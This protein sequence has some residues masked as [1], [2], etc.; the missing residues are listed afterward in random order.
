MS[1]DLWFLF[2]LL[3]KMA[4][5][6]GFVVVASIITERAGPAIG[7][8][9]STLPVS[10]GPSF[11]F[12]SLDHD[13]AFIEG[14]ALGSL[15]INAVTAFFALSYVL[16]AQRRSLAVSLAISLL[17]WF[18]LTVAIRQFDWTTA[19]I[20]VLNI[21]AFAIC[22]PLGQRFRHAKMPL[23]TR[24][25]YDVPLRAAMVS[26]LVAIVVT[27]SRWVGPTM[28]GTIA[29]YPIVFTCLILILHPRIGGPA[30]AA[31]L[32]HGLWGLIGFG[33]ATLVLQHAAVPL[34]SPA[35]LS[36]ALATAIAWNFGLWLWRRAATRRA[37]RP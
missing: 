17:V 36:L 29:T 33:A 14:A 10:A 22:I 28:S 32:A 34:G 8:L 35:A 20:I 23:M 9:V 31:V 24:R 6:A 2:T 4:I 15:A 27:T 5:T 16:L 13:A 3:L 12:L 30:T 21:I 26:T 37:S 1:P 25:W 11:V 19:G 18:A 7:A